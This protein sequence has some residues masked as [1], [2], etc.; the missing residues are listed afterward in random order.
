[1]GVKEKKDIC[2]DSEMMV[3]IHTRQASIHTQRRQR[4]LGNL[5]LTDSQG[6]EM[7]GK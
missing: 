7:Q 5:A 4:F 3:L 1:M 2:H 6:E